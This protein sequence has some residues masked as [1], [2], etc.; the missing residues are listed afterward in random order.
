M[1]S[2]FKKNKKGLYDTYEEL[3]NISKRAGKEFAKQNFHSE[4][5]LSDREG[6]YI[7]EPERTYYDSSS[8]TDDLP[9]EAKDIQ[10]NHPEISN[11]ARNVL[12]N[13]NKIHNPARIVNDMDY[14]KSENNQITEE[15]KNNMAILNEN[16]MILNDNLE[17]LK[18][19]YD[20]LKDAIVNMQKNSLNIILPKNAD[21]KTMPSQNNN[22]DSSIDTNLEFQ[23]NSEYLKNNNEVNQILKKKKY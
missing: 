14:E 11:Y 2:K 10:K 19:K 13:R 22:F 7:R 16:V 15:I 20:G 9:Q 6:F 18:S 1:K 23:S 3:D 8:D 12:N 5:A 4:D 21:K 17:L